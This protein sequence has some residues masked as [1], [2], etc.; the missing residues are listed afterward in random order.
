[1]PTQHLQFWLAVLL[2]QRHWFEATVIAEKV[3]LV[4]NVVQLHVMLPPNP[5]EQDERVRLEGQDWPE[6]Y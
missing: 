5:H 6:R 2:T 4:F 3:A 1:V